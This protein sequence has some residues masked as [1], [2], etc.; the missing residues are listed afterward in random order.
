MYSAK[1]LESVDKSLHKDEIGGDLIEPRLS[2]DILQGIDENV[3]PLR[4]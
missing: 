1:V 4:T 3:N 2:L